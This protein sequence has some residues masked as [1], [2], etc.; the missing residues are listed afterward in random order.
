MFLFFEKLS[1]TITTTQFS[2]E[3]TRYSQNLQEDHIH[4]HCTENHIKS[5]NRHFWQIKKTEAINEFGS[6]VH[7]ENCLKNL[8]VLEEAECCGS[9][10]FSNKNSKTYVESFYFL[11]NKVC[12][13]LTATL[14]KCAKMLRPTFSMPFM[15][16]RVF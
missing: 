7:S 5:L 4:V 10:L 13:D 11:C 14:T 12:F 15:T 3:L 9:L 2:N 16:T 8:V 1:Q 6:K